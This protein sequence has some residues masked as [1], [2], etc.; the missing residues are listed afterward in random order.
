MLLAIMSGIFG[1]AGWHFCKPR[2]FRSAQL[3]MPA[4]QRA[5]PPAPLRSELSPRPRTASPGSRRA[6]PAPTSTTRAV[7]PASRRMPLRPS[8]S[9]SSPT[10]LSPRYALPLPAASNGYPTPSDARLS[11]LP[12]TDHGPRNSTTPTTSGARM[13]TE[14]NPNQLCV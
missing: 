12:C 13:A 11:P 8:T 7:T 2:I 9:L 3:L 14:K 1:L 10:S 6:A 4:H 5:P